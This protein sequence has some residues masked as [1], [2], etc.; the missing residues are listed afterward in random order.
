MTVDNNA[1]SVVA[2]AVND[3]HLASDDSLLVGCASLNAVI[4]SFDNATLLMAR[5]GKLHISDNGA[6]I[7]SAFPVPITQATVFVLVSSVLSML[8]GTIA[9]SGNSV[10]SRVQF[11]CG[12][13]QL[14]NTQLAA[15]ARV[16]AVLWGNLSIVNNSLSMNVSDEGGN[17]ESSPAGACTFSAYWATI[18][19]SL[20][21]AA[22]GGGRIIIS[23]NTLLEILVGRANL[24]GRLRFLYVL[25]TV[26][27]ALLLDLPII[28]EKY[29]YDDARVSVV[30][31]RGD[32]IVAHGDSAV[33]IP[34]AIALSPPLTNTSSPL[35]FAIDGSDIEGITLRGPP[36]LLIE[37]NAINITVG[38]EFVILS[39]RI[40]MVSLLSVPQSFLAVVA[41][42]N[43]FSIMVRNASS[44]V[45]AGLYGV[46]VAGSL[47]V[48]PTA[49]NNTQEGGIVTTNNT[50]FLWVEEFVDE[51][52]VASVVARLA[53]VNLKQLQILAPPLGTLRRN[54]RRAAR[55]GTRSHPRPLRPHVRFN[56]CCASDHVARYRGG[57][58]C[59]WYANRRQRVCCDGCGGGAARSRAGTGREQLTDVAA[60]GAA[61]LNATEQHAPHLHR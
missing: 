13:S 8:N 12:A 46:D 51:K 29:P 1:L 5:S 22:D 11:I 15:V 31:N 17:S 32:Y 41:R 14:T 7:A 52:V 2:A 4:V 61:V 27:K 50:L 9:V 34:A 58:A 49:T 23:N 19:V 30:G 56:C 26:T 16:S 44:V 43:K 53:P 59:T 25:L 55:H 60:A 39:G 37:N 35:R 47:S 42:D 45:G 54:I 36:I 48:T 28:V 24:V 10:L 33:T 57:L 3:G 6:S 21:A 40:V 38:P 20:A 18:N